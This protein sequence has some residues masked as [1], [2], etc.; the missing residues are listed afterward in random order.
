MTRTPLLVVLFAF[1]ALADIPPQ[2]SSGCRDKNAGASCKRD[3]G[4]D[5]TCATST[6][7]K[8]DYSGGVPPKQVTYECLK[9]GASAP[10]PSVS[11]PQPSANSPQP[12]VSSPPA[13]PDKA[14]KNTCAAMPG[15]SLAA[16]SLLLLALR[17]SRRAP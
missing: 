14:S 5:G 3:D 6:C 9:C 7:S 13:E 16:L 2:D 12:G 4:S 10:Q 17:R 11:S 1:T 15:E 8:N